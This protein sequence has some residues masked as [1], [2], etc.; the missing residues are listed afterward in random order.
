MSITKYSNFEDINKNIENEGKFLQYDDLFIVTKGE[1]EDT[2]F[3]ECKYDVMEVSVYDI[4]NNLLP[5]KSGNNVAYIKTGDIKNYMY[6]VTNT[7]GKKEFAIDIETLLNKLGFT[8]GILKV[9][10]NFV[11]NRVGSENELTRVWIQEISPSR[12][13]IRILPLKVSDSNIT[14]KN[15]KDFSNINNLNQDF[16]YYKKQILDTLDSFENENITKIND[17]IVSKF[18]NDFLQVLKKDFGLSNFETFRN[19]IFSNFKDSVTYWVNNKE[20]DITQ[21]NYGNPLAI[22]RFEDCEQYDFQNL[23]AELQNILFKSVEVNIKTLKRRN[24]TIKSIPKEFTVVELRKE[25]KDNIDSYATKTERKRIVYSPNTVSVAFDDVPPQPPIIEYPKTEI[26]VIDVP[27]IEPQL[28]PATVIK[29]IYE[30]API[31]IP[32]IIEDAFPPIQDTNIDTPFQIPDRIIDTPIE[33]TSGG[34]GSRGDGT[35]TNQFDRFDDISLYEDRSME[36]Q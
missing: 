18:G 31:I 16:K 23:I 24:T 8:N 1:I 14:E 13:E 7:V 6:N 9:N 33:Y 30:P 32:D 29:P 19:R 26:S 3:G 10:I 4:N 15:K 27:P 12:E 36:I 35:I 22:K 25:I 21:S 5:Q 17:A 34:G 2:D 20:Y 11:R 28:I